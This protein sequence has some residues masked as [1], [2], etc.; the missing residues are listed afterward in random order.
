MKF[1]GTSVAGPAR[2][3]RA[4]ERAIAAARRGRSVVVVASAP[5]RMTDDLI[6]L[7]RSVHPE[8]DERELDLL[9]STGEMVGISLLAIAIRARGHPAV[10]FTGPQAGIE[11]D[12]SHTRAHIVRIRPA[13]I[14]RA[15]RQGAIVIV[16]GFQGSNPKADIATLGRG[17]SDLT[18]VALAASLG[19]T[20]CE[21]FTDVRGVF[22]AD[23]SLVPD[24]RLLGRISCSEMLELA[25]AGA[26]VMHARSIEVAQ[27]FGVRIRVRSSFEPGPGTWIEEGGGTMEEASISSLALD[28]GEV[29]LTVVGV[30]D[31]PGTAARVLASLSAA[32][33]PVDMIVQSWAV[34]GGVNHISLMT[35]RAHA[36]RARE[37]LAGAA[38]RLGAERVEV[39]ERVAKVSVVGT[40][41]RHHSWVPTRV[42]ETLARERI[43]IEMIVTSDNRIAVVVALAGARKALRALHA[44]LRLPRRPKAGRPQR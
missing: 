10:S 40:G 29:R 37:A 20:H 34:A 18:A 25:S 36:R 2:I 19:A 22:T 28:T 5:G 30:P 9:M 24:A 8:P 11:A 14:E 43:N 26:Q 17:G 27:R 38:K 35:P 42:F 7:A 3:H 16:A 32:G 21:I 6:A 44:A 4:A 31:K 13:R 12:E 41:F 39:D 1:G 33:I 15:L 23:P